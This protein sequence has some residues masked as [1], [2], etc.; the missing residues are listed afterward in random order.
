MQII[1]N[2]T[3]SRVQYAA[4]EPT[5]TQLNKHTQKHDIPAVKRNHATVLINL[6]VVYCPN[7]SGE[8]KSGGT[9]G[10][11]WPVRSDK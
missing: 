5:T 6:D 4:F 2:E 8:G 10:M 9:H 1:G 3:D 7:P 11:M